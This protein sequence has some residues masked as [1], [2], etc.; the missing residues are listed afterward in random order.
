MFSR[1]SRLASLQ[2]T[3]HQH[4]WNLLVI[5]PP[6]IVDVHSLCFY[7][8]VDAIYFALNSR[9]QPS[10]LYLGKSNFSKLSPREK[11]KF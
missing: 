10:T 9:Q 3:I 8:G 1:Y 5:T 4:S 11:D 2:S 7:E 6:T